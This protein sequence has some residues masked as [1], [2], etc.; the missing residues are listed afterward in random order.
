MA[1]YLK[2]DD[3]ALAK[4]FGS[5]D[6]PVG[7]HLKRTVIK[8]DRGAK[9]RCPVDTGRLRASIANEIG[10]DDRG[11]VG[12]VGTNVEYAPHVEY[13]TSRMNAQPF[14]RPALD[15]AK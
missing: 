5:A 10:Q 13:G 6:G 7:K 11:L 3:D 4:L 1:S 2:F 8:V 15:D 14:L 12:R 9:R